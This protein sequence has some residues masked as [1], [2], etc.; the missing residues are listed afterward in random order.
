MDLS[1]CVKVSHKTACGNAVS[2]C[3]AWVLGLRL[4]S[5]LFTGLTGHVSFCG[6]RIAGLLFVLY[7]FNVFITHLFLIL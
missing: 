6:S 3:I 1:T 5:R 4:D 7:S 2:P